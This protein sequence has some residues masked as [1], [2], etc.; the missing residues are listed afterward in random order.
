MRPPPNQPAGESAGQR[1]NRV[2]KRYTPAGG[3]CRCPDEILADA[4][5]RCQARSFIQASAAELIAFSPLTDTC[6]PCLHGYVIMRASG[7]GWPCVNDYRAYHRL[8]LD[9]RRECSEWAAWSPH[10]PALLQ[11]ARV[12]LGLEWSLFVGSCV[13]LLAFTGDAH[14]GSVN[15]QL[16]ASG[17]SAVTLS[18]GTR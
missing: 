11:C 5:R 18:A 2:F 10:D 3:V 4:V 15:V 17:N 16:L 12:S 13:P 6:T 8:H 1:L 7:R 9:G 14:R